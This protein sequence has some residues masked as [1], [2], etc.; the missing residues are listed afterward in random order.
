MLG[1]WVA[2]N[3]IH[4]LPVCEEKERLRSLYRKAADAYTAAVN[5]LIAI[6]GKTTE[7]DYHRVRGVLTEAR[8]ARDTARRALEEHKQKHGC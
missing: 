8:N 1:G 2:A 3:P 7:E 6:R 4:L 5:D